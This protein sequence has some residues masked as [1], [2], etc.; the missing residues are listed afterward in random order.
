MKKLLSI[1][2]SCA[3][4]IGLLSVVSFA[5]GASESG[6]TLD[7][8]SAIGNGSDETDTTKITDEG[9]GFVISQTKPWNGW[10]LYYDEENVPAF[11]EAAGND[12]YLVYDFTL[13]GDGHLCLNGWEKSVASAIAAAQGAPTT[14][15]EDGT[16]MLTTNWY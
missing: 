11:I 8:I 6:A 7:L 10:V 4:L 3:L 9:S 1:V 14:P 12:L 16:P 5:D 15:A 2:I 13:N